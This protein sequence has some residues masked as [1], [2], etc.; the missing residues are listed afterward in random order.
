MKIKFIILPIFVLTII[1]H[2]Q[3]EAVPFKKC[4]TILI[5][6]SLNGNETFMKW[7]KHLIQ[8]GFTLDKTN[9]DFLTISTVP[10]D[11]SRYNMDFILN[12]SISDSGNIMLNIKWRV[13]SSILAETDATEFYDWEYSKSK[14]NIQNIIYNDILPMI[15]SFGEYIVTYEKR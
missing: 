3:S 2:G 7:G 9:K 5:Q 11:A 8:S 15:K 10:K 1:C 14:G 13:K 12:S 4:N 6:T